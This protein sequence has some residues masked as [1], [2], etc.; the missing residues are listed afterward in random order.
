MLTDTE[1]SE[2]LQD[3]NP[4]QKLYDICKAKAEALRGVLGV[5]STTP[6]KTK[7]KKEAPDPEKETVAKEEGNLTDDQIY[8]EVKDLLPAHDEDDD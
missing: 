2:F 4:A 5:Q 6:P 8:D 1:R 3:A 7:P